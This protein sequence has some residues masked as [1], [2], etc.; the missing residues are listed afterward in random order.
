MAVEQ[1]SKGRR[2]RGERGQSLVELA[3]TLPVLV[4]VAELGNS[5]NAYITVVDV[6]RDG[7]RLGSKG[8]ATDAQIQNLVVTETDRLPN[9]VQLT[10][11]TVT[12]NVMSGYPDRLSIRVTVCYDH[13]PILPVPLVIPN[14]LRMCSTTTM[15]VVG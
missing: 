4:G 3:L 15:P 5:L 2:G 10:D 6:A 14:P 13:S 12:R 7:A 11:I 1:R 9:Q 8:G